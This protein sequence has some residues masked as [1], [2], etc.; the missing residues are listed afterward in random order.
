MTGKRQD[1]DTLNC[2]WQ[3]ETQ[4]IKP[5][6]QG[7]TKHVPKPSKAAVQP[8]AAYH[9]RHEAEV[10]LTIISHTATRL[11]GLAP[12]QDPK[13]LKELAAGKYEATEVYDL[14]GYRAAEA[15]QLLMESLH[16]AAREGH[17]CVLVITGKGHGHGER[18]DMGLL[19]Y[20]LPDWLRHHPRVL[21]FHTADTAAGGAGAV[22]VYLR[23]HRA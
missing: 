22:Y 12:G 2:P 5:L 17:R 14:H 3:Q 19:K 21:A 4:T 16:E 9:P 8:P 6:S 7:K 18:A 20:S 15:W 23:R 13:I 1:D 10:P 11:A